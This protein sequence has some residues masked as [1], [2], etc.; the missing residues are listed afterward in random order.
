VQIRLIYLATVIANLS[1]TS[2]IRAWRD[3]ERTTA[4]ILGIEWR[5]F[6]QYQIDQ[7]TYHMVRSTRSMSWE[8]RPNNSIRA[9]KK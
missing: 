2:S 6:L 3:A 1:S 7:Y 5:W 8:M 4:A 9:R